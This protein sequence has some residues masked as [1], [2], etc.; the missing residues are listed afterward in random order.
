MATPMPCTHTTTHVS[1]LNAEN[2]CVGDGYLSNLKAGEVLHTRILEEDEVAVYVRNVFDS[3]CE[4]DEPFEECLGKCAQTVI[5]WKQQKI[6]YTAKDAEIP[7]HIHSTS[8]SH[9]FQAFEW[10]EESGPF[11][12][13][14]QFPVQQKRKGRKLDHNLVHMQNKRAS[15]CTSIA[16]ED[17]QFQ[18]GLHQKEDGMEGPLIVKWKRNYTR[19]TRKPSVRPMMRKIGE[20]HLEKVLL[21]SVRQ[22]TTKST[23]VK[24]CLTN[25]SE[26]KIMDV[27]YDVWENSRTHDE[28]VTWILR[29]M[30]TFVK[31]NA[32]T[33]WMDFNFYI[34]G[35]SVCSTCYAHV[36]GYS[37]RQLERWKEDI[38]SRD[39][40]SA[41]YGNALKPHETDH[42]ATARVVFQKY[43]SGC[44]CP[45]PHRQ[46]YQKKDGIFLPLVLL[47]MN[48]KKNDIRAL[49]NE[50]LLELREKEISASAFHAMWRRY[51]SHVQ[52]PK[53]SRFSKC[54]VC[55]EFTS[56]LEK[57]VI[58]TM[59]DRLKQIYQRHHELQCQER[60]AYKDVKLDARNRPNKFLSIVVDGIDQNTTMVPKMRQTVKNIEGRYVK[61]H[62]CGVLVHGWGLYCDVWIDAHYRHDSNQVVN[63]VHS[64]RGTVPP[65]LYIQ[66]DNCIRENKNK[67]PFGLC[68][69]LVGL[70][71]FEEARV[72]FFLVGHT[73]S[74]IDQ[75]FSSISHVLKGDDINSLSKLL[76][77]LQNQFPGHADEPVQYAQLMEN[78]WDWKG[79]ITPHLQ[80]SRSAEFI[81][82]SEPHHFRFFQRNSVLHVQYKIYANDAWG[83]SD[84][85]PFLASL[86]DVRSKPG[87]AEVFQ[88]NTEEVAALC[89][90]SNLKERQLHRLT[91]FNATDDVIQ[92]Y[93]TV[94]VETKA[95]IEYLQEFPNSDRTLV[96]AS[97]KF[98]WTSPQNK[99]SDEN[100]SGEPNITR[101]MIE[102]LSCFPAVEHCGYFGPRGGAPTKLGL[103]R[104][105]P[106]SK[107][108]VASKYIGKASKLGSTSTDPIS[109]VVPAQHQ[110][111]FDFDP[112]MD[113]H[114]GDFVGV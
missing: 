54:N 109:N 39:R 20:D 47:P 98:W 90:F 70:G 102:I 58:N 96:H 45:Q 17:V 13:P 106:K 29:Q 72:G 14:E 22:W 71:Y 94:I 112:H 97:A 61:T 56:T 9:C 44:G 107:K 66:A 103:Q 79:F 10:T 75:R 27:R 16:S 65:I 40:R 67:F 68:A 5:R 46:H 18:S 93:Q 23:C 85:H 76:K 4:V 87:F 50:S 33:R 80:S 108:D 69:T 64:A 114:I 100:T 15:L 34:E 19:I 11:Q 91:R 28:R 12:I 51:F 53:T 89:S 111:W 31:Q 35:T 78:I 95:F 52:I 38:R 36:L 41:Y 113:V 59:K 105:V 42:V 7:P 99:A 104:L 84:G 2:C 8:P 32:V 88:A 110:R 3:T 26:R 73:H 48:T 49:I 30:W 25:I 74:D 63:A 101:D 92:M 57:V 86:L 24:Q 62:L 82:M 1:L 83:P 21:K 81:G 43:I 55:W 60:D 77:L 6:V 37:R